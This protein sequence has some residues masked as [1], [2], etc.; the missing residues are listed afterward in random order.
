MQSSFRRFLLTA[1]WFESIEAVQAF[2]D[3]MFA[4]REK[5]GLSSHFAFHF[6][7]LCQERKSIFFDAVARQSFTVVFSSFEKQGFDPKSL[8]KGNIRQS[9]VEGLVKGLEPLYRAAEERKAGMGTLAERV[10]YA[11]CNGADYEKLLRT[12]FRSLA[13]SRVENKRLIAD[14]KSK[15]AETDSCLQLADMVCGAVGKHIDGDSD[16]YMRIKD[17]VSMTSRLIRNEKG[18]S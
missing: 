16:Y 10:V 9:T 12:H 11:K 8:T 3:D 18:T 13:S 14:I 4:L 1:V 6:A 5:S 15:R 17:K 2:N 7:R